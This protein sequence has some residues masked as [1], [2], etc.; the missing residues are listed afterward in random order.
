MLVDKGKMKQG[1]EMLITGMGLNLADPNLV[2]TPDRIVRAWMEMNS[3]LFEQHKIPS[4]F[5]SVFPSTY[6]Q[7]V[8]CSNIH[9]VGMCPHHFMPV[10]YTIHI[11]YIPNEEGMVVGISKLARLATILAMRPVLQEQ[12]T[13]DIA[14][15]LEKYLSP[16]GI[17]VVAIGKHSCMRLRGARA[18]NSFITT[19]VIKGVLR[20]KMDA[21]TEFLELLKRE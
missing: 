17:G 4:L 10:E 16:L 21:R 1:A 19:S 3:G 15:E 14:N 7:M 13:E 11:G 18:D 8:L 9:V 2:D 20:E 5:T 6:D 12:L